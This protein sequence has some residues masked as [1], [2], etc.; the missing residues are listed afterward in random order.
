MN[1]FE[2]FR[3]YTKLAMLAI[4]AYVEKNKMSSRKKLPMVGLK[5]VRLMFCSDALLTGLT[6]QVLI[7]GYLTSLLFGF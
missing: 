7:E 6:W 5:L 4:K 1:A 2:V 3:K